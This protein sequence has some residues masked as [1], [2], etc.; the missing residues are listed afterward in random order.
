MRFTTL[1]V[2]LVCMATGMALGIK[3]ESPCGGFAQ[4]FFFYLAISHCYKA[5]REDQIVEDSES[6]ANQ[7]TQ[8][9]RSV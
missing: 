6:F 3:L 1:V 4:G 8:H 5:G 2:S 9:N 7:L